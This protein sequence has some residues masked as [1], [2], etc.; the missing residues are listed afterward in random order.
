[1]TSS[2]ISRLPKLAQASSYVLLHQKHFRTPTSIA[3]TALSPNKR[4]SSLDSRSQ[5]GQAAQGE[6]ALGVETDSRRLVRGRLMGGLRKGAVVRDWDGVGDVR[7]ADASFPVVP[8]HS[9]LNKNS[10]A[11]LRSLF[12]T[13]PSTLSNSLSAVFSY[14]DAGKECAESWSR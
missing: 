4:S 10:T 11:P 1:L 5:E 3:F 12:R 8:V 6:G 2:S 14:I 7:F 9:S 13:G